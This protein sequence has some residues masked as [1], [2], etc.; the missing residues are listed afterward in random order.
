VKAADKATPLQTFDVLMRKDVYVTFLATQ[1]DGKVK[2]EMVDDTY[3]PVD[4]PAGRL[5]VRNHFPDAQVSVT[6]AGQIKSRALASGEAQVLDGFPLGT[7]MLQMQAKLPSGKV[8]K[9][10]TEVDFRASKHASL[11]VVPDAYGRFRPRLSLDGPGAPAAVPPPAAL[12]VAPAAPAT[13]AQR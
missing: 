2:V 3:N 1:V 10:S 5:T 8:Q 6:G 11:L 9:W 7:V 12:S 4:V 13:T